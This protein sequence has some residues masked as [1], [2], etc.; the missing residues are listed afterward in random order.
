DHQGSLWQSSEVLDQAA[1]RVDQMHGLGSGSETPRLDVL[2]GAGTGLLADDP[3][4]LAGG[5]LGG[6][7]EQALLHALP[8]LEFHCSW[9]MR[10][11]P[12]L[13]LLRP[14]LEN[15]P[16]GRNDLPGWQSSSETG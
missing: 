15:P 16:G 4:G 6:D 11:L 9:S 12:S 10:V 5:T 7:D 1:K 13:R 14:P 8:A 3:P 2:P